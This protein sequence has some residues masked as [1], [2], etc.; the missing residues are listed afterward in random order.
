MSLACVAIGIPEPT[1]RLDFDG[2]GIDKSYSFLTKA[3]LLIA[4]ITKADNGLIKC[5]A[6]SILG[7]GTEETT[8]DVHT[9]PKINLPKISTK[10]EIGKQAEIYCNASSSP[11]PRLRWETAAA[12]VNGIQHFSSDGRSLPLVIKSPMAGDSGKYFSTAANYIGK[13][14]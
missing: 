10:P 7:K 5:E 1:I 13:V 14:N 11:L 3:S 2:R 4:N 12:A 8:L 9:K 6:E